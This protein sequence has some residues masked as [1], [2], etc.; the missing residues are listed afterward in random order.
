MHNEIVLENIHY[1]QAGHSL[2]SEIS[3]TVKQNEVMALL[4]TNGAGK[5][6]LLR[7]CAGLL[8]PTTG[9]L[10]RA[11]ENLGQAIG[12][13]PEIPPLLPQ[14]TVKSFLEYACRQRGIRG[15]AMTAAIQR[16]TD[17]CELSAVFK[18]RIATLSKG[19]QQRVA[20]AQA[21][22]HQPKLL[23]LDEPTAGLDPCQINHFRAL[24]ARIQPHA[25]IILSSHIMQ[26]VISLCDRVAILHRG[27][28][29]E[30][31][32][33][34]A[35]ANV[36]VIRFAHEVTHEVHQTQALQAFSSWRAKVG[37]DYTFVFNHQGEKDALLAF[38][39]QKQWSIDKVLDA[40]QLLEQQFLQAV[41]FD[42][43]GQLP[44]GQ[45]PSGQLPSEQLP[46]EQQ[47]NAHPMLPNNDGVQNV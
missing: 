22:L 25:T 9:K 2:L 13:V 17:D 41:G 45:L 29:V 20:I 7:I 21:L 8:V 10:Y 47:P 46:S 34:N 32:D 39:L 15:A 44:N 27:Q 37:D 16:V 19:N 36:C 38:C 40:S 5:S 30:L 18:K 4:G 42:V 24:I 6:T 1:E 43:E 28:L 23:L 31:L 12:Y 35:Q 33:I 26:E 3:L 11:H 14:W